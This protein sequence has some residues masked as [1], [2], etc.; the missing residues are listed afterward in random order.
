MNRFFLVVP[1][2]LISEIAWMG[3]PAQGV[4]EKQWWR[5]EWLELFNVSEQSLRIDGWSV[6]LSRDKLDFSIP[7]A[8]TIPPKGYFVMGAS[9]KISHADI[10]Y[11][12]LAGKFNNAGQL[13]ALKDAKGEIV[14]SIDAISGWPAGN[15]KGKYTMERK[16]G[17]PADEAGWQ[18][19]FIASGTPGAKNS[20][21]SFIS[22][23]NRK[24]PAE[25]FQNHLN[26]FQKPFAIASLAAVLSAALFVAARRRLVF[27][28]NRRV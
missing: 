28:P 2:I 16:N 12:N 21:S 7:L 18:T 27:P 1:S 6:E 10:S 20:E 23:E 17:L 3:G 19:S 8:G 9:D 15:N 5:Y 14:D 13:V 25:S 11:G 22:K 4:D 24:D 26:I